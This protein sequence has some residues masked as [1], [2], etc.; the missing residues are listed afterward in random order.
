MAG[1]PS[2]IEP[3]QAADDRALVAALRAG[4]ERAF[5]V[6][7]ERYGAALLRVAR[8]YVKDMGA[9]EDVVQETWLGVFQGIDR[10]EERASFK[11]W[12]FTILMNRAKRRGER[13]SRVAPF[14]AVAAGDAAESEID[15]FFPAGRDFAGHWSSLPRDWSALP[16][17]R[18]ESAETRAVIDRA[19]AA[20]PRQQRAVITLRDIEGWPSDAIRNALGVSETNQRVLLHRARGK[21]R[22]ALE[23]YFGR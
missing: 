16:E 10:F 18:V 20:L 6:L 21:V 23:E 11:T 2:T 1:H 7:M 8:L 22:R 12:L 13:D 5:V 19:I 4:D 14:S 15:R 9:A 17:A 3:F